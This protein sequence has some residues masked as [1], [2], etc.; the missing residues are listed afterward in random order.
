MS[1]KEI[2][3]L[4][5]GYVLISLFVFV[6]TSFAKGRFTKEGLNY[7][8]TASGKSKQLTTDP[9]AYAIAGEPNAAG[10]YIKLI[11]TCKDG[12]QSWNTFD[13]NAIKTDTLEDLLKEFG[14]ING[15]SAEP[16]SYR[17][18]MDSAPITLTSKLQTPSTVNCQY[19]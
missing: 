7:L 3:W 4:L 9:C 10:K 19:E 18:D 6:G 12:R 8:V 16:K 17:C 11:V 15:V 5:T 14:R 1:K 13:A 2:L